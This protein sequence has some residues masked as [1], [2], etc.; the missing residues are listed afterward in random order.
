MSIRA[1]ES[2]RDF[3]ARLLASIGQPIL[4]TDTEFRVIYWNRGAEQMLGWTSDEMLGVD[5]IQATGIE[6]SDSRSDSLFEELSAGA[7][8]TE[9]FQVTARDG[10]RFPVLAHLTPL[11]GEAGEFVGIVAIGTDISDRY[12]LERKVADEHQ[13]L[14]QAQ[15]IA[16]IGSF[17]Y[18]LVSETMSWSRELR[19]IMGIGEHTPT[20]E[21]FVNILP[22]EDL[23]IFIDHIRE[24]VR[25]GATDIDVT[26]RIRR[27][28][29]E[30]RWMRT[31]GRMTYHA[32][33]GVPTRI[34]GST[35]DITETRRDEEARRIAEQRFSVA[36]DFGSVGMCILGLDRKV[37]Q[38]N[39]TIC[40]MF[41]R[42]PQELI[43]H[44]PDEF[45]H[46]SDLVPGESPTE[47][48]LSSGLDH[49]EMERRYLRPDGEQFHAI[50]HLGVVR[51]ADGTPLYT[52][53]QVVDITDRKRSEE[54]L[55][56]LAMQDPLTGLPNRSLL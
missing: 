33:T 16:K 11:F 17:D 53:A 38:V 5:I 7:G 25:S 14:E 26:Y 12:E 21:Q 55:E 24:Q 4:A 35:Q 19:R 22:P 9:D 20:R 18:D 32:S 15:Q 40:R 41:G 6:L 23:T 54:E 42:A 46:P 10:T 39:A 37:R 36:F 3:A 49:V 13:Q 47:M 8:V 56:R 30:T 34:V 43:G 27:P 28:D 1:N 52:L 44:S 48:L 50:V 31:L 45:S 29:G 2:Q 51:D